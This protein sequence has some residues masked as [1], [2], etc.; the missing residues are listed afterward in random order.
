MATAVSRFYL[1]INE[2]P[3]LHSV[4]RIESLTEDIYR[5]WLMECPAQTDLSLRGGRQ[6]DVAIFT[7]RL[8]DCFTPAEIRNDMVITMTKTAGYTPTCHCEE[9]LSPTWQSLLTG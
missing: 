1:G 4:G 6:P 5:V 9:G 8:G 7:N 3:H 2:I